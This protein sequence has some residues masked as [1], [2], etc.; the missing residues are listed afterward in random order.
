MV[1]VMNDYGACVMGD[2]DALWCVSWMI[3]VPVM[4]DCGACHGWLWCLC[5][6]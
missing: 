2:Y 1:P 4:D 5:H 6:G 3:V